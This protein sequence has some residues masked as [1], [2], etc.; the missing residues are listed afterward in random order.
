MNDVLEQ[1][2]TDLMFQREDLEEVWRQQPILL[3]QYGFK[4]SQAEKDVAE[5]KRS[6]DAIEARL[7]DTARKDLSMSGIKF[8]ESTLEAKV[9]TSV[10]YLAKR[11]TL[12]DARHKADI[13]KHAVSAFN[14]R[15]DM[16]I[17]AS[18]LAIIEIERL[19]AE[20]FS[21]P[22]PL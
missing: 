15:K 12:D 9:K 6:L 20:R 8:N 13:Y 16:I 14:H 11:Q 18:K 19:G 22:R 1:I 17:Q 7:Y 5:A 21:R 4:L 3:M 10:T 2:I